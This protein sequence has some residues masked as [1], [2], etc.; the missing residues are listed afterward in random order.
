MT[1]EE[2]ARLQALVDWQNDPTL[3][4]RC[5]ALRT[6]EENPGPRPRILQIDF[7]G[8]GTSLYQIQENGFWLLEIAPPGSWDVPP[9][10]HILR[11]ALELTGGLVWIKGE[12]FS[13]ATLT[14]DDEA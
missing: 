13:Q 5:D 3:H 9:F 7:G 12:G 11:R 4:P 1:P 6:L 14:E 10:S 2:E 8:G